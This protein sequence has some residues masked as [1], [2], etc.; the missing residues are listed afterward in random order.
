MRLH[1]V[2][3]SAKLARLLNIR[4]I[5]GRRKHNDRQV[6]EFG[7]RGEPLQ[8]FEAMH[9]RHFQIQQ[10]ECWQWMEWPV[11]KTSNTAEVIHTL[12]ATLDR[13]QRV[14][15]LCPCK[16]Q[17]QNE[18]VGFL[19]L[20][21]EYRSHY[22]VPTLSLFPPSA[23]GRSTQKLLPAPGSDSTPTLPPMRSTTLRTMA[24]PIPVP[25]YSEWSF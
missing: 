24:R 23:R 19:V 22:G 13:H 12:S 18:P 9:A 14:R 11:D 10:Q 25:S 17:V 2:I 8:N 21:C 1:D 16:G 4:S 7:P 6:F 3:A 5:R 15:Q 20:G